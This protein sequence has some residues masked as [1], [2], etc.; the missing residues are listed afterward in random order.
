MPGSM[1]SFDDIKA[2]QKQLMRSFIDTALEAEMEDHLGYP[3][4]F[5][6]YIF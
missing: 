5:T 3:K 4:Q 1:N 2:F 6:F